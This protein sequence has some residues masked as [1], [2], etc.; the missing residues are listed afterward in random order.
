M[1]GF[2]DPWQV[3]GDASAALS[4]V[5]TRGFGAPT[6]TAPILN[7]RPSET[8]WDGSINSFSPLTS[9]SSALLPFSSSV[10]KRS[11][12]STPVRKGIEA[13][14]KPLSAPLCGIVNASA[15]SSSSCMGVPPSL[16]CA[17]VNKPLVPEFIWK[18]SWSITLRAAGGAIESPGTIRESVV[19]G[20]GGNES[21]PGTGS[22]TEA[23]ATIGA[24]M[25]WSAVKKSAWRASLAGAREG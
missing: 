3:G 20:E 10:I 1:V 2:A 12:G 8:N 11:E 25:F 4:I 17:G 15:T 24:G 6:P 14:S 18:G 22:G 21:P 13:A 7:W 19:G 23:S 9:L 5:S 16:L